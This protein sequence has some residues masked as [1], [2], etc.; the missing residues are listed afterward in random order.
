[1]EEVGSLA[2]KKRPG[3]A[4]RAD[5]P[6][7]ERL[8]PRDGGDGASDVALNLVYKDGYFFHSSETSTLK[9]S[10]I[11]FNVTMLGVRLPVRM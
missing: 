8:K 7:P 4:A 6:G 9:A 2:A 1:M 3:T 11:F 5:G 10:E